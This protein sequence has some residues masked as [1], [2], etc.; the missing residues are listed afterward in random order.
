MRGLIAAAR[1]VVRDMFAT[2]WRLVVSVLLIALPVAVISA[3]TIDSASVS[4]SFSS[5]QPNFTLKYQGGQCTQSADGGDF[6]C[7]G[8]AEDG[9]IARN[10]PANFAAYL[11]DNLPEGIEAGLHVSLDASVSSGLGA[12]T[13]TTIDQWPLEDF[14]AGYGDKLENGGIVLPHQMSENL[15]INIGDSVTVTTAI[16][17]Q[18]FTVSGF[19]PG[20][21][22]AVTPGTLAKDAAEVF[23]VKD[24]P[25]DYNLPDWTL[26]SS[27]D[28]TWD[29]VTQLN[30]AGFT[31]HPKQGQ[32]IVGAPEVPKSSGSHWHF[33]FSTS[34]SSILFG[35][36]VV[37]I[38]AIAALLILLLLSP[39]FALAFNRH[40]RMFALMSS[41]G[42]SPRQI[43]LA[44]L[45]YAGLTGLLGGITGLVVG[46]IVET[47]NWKVTYPD[48]P[49][50]LAPMDL[51]GYLAIAV[52]GA[53]L[54]ALFPAFMV[55]RNALAAD[56]A[57]AEPDRILG[58]RKW[59]AIGPAILAI[60]VI[61][62]IGLVIAKGTIALD[63]IYNASPIFIL[64]AIIG[65]ATSTPA[66]LLGTARMLQN[67]PLPMRTASR[68]LLRRSARVLPVVAAIVCVT[69]VGT[70]ALMGGAAD[71]RAQLEAETRTTSSPTVVVKT[72]NLFADQPEQQDA[73][74]YTDL[75]TQLRA[76]A[77]RVAEKVDSSQTLELRSVI[78]Y[79]LDGDGVEI[80]IKPT[81]NCTAIRP[82]INF[83]TM[84]PEDF[85]GSNGKSAAT[86][87]R[88]AAGCVQEITRFGSSSPV[89]ML[90]SAALVQK[91]AEVSL[92]ALSPEEKAQA[93]RILADGGVL[94][95]RG[96]SL[97]N[98]KATIQIFEDGSADKAQRS[99]DFVA[100]A[101]LPP[102][103]STEV[104]LSEE[105]A[106]ELKVPVQTMGYAIMLNQAA[107][108]YDVDSL[109]A[110]TRQLP[111]QFSDMIGVNPNYHLQ[112]VADGW[113]GSVAI[114][115]VSLVAIILVIALAASG[116]RRDNATLIS[117]GASPKLVARIAAIEAALTTLLGMGVGVVL[118]HITMALLATHDQYSA[119]GDLISL[120]MSQHI[121]PDW[122]LIGGVFAVTA[123]ASLLAWFI[124]R[125]GTTDADVARRRE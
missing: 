118:G 76:T 1:P 50:T 29:D 108:D 44:V 90:D 23:A 25:N 24:A 98:G 111:S 83:T 7:D 26:T 89:D 101:V 106:H 32:D 92:W 122:I 19:S 123:I 96:T 16:S 46:I 117:I 105:A 8:A 115:G 9:G 61:I 116:L 55:S 15:G 87:P 53:M 91:P 85:V 42:A 59:M 4:R 36:V 99:E 34:L 47:I 65:L 18:K 54:S 30:K 60:E 48:W 37:S 120:G 72:S 41:Q 71:S 43:R 70:I 38:Y 81:G 12:A 17:S 57:G 80:Q 109:N 5:E 11:K 63:W 77:G 114:V 79:Y 97:T 82:N 27:R 78:P 94:V 10:H 95:P 102:H 14:P 2:K 68:G 3:L 67:S 107:A 100:A 119:A 6:D 31:V 62:L 33:D 125:P 93:E 84:S 112:S 113:K 110:V 58:W 39:V 56:I 66:M 40:T 35:A 86:D 52:V 124:H 64:V 21:M 28:I 45:T 13:R 121:R 103:S 22:A 73:T 51:A 104:V 74:A 49:M 75:E 69:F 88:A 20:P